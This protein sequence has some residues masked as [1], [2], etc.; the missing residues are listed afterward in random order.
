[1]KKKRRLKGW[2]IDTIEGIGLAI[3]ALGFALMIENTNAISITSNGLS[4]FS[5]NIN[6]GFAVLMIGCVIASI[7]IMIGDRKYD[8]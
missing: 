3:G 7:V 5:I 2:V 8:I 6:T 1:M 4:D